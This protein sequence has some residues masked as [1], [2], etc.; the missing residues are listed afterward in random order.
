MTWKHLYESRVAAMQSLPGESCQHRSDLAAQRLLS[1]NVLSAQ[2]RRL[3]RLQ[4]AGVLE[5]AV[6]QKIEIE[7]D[8]A[9]IALDRLEWRHE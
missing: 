1:M 5:H 8:L 3:V 6:M 7:L 9:E 2:R 4:K